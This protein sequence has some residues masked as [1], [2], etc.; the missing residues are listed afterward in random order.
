MAR[1]GSRRTLHRRQAKAHRHVLPCRCPIRGA[2]QQASSL[3][4]MKMTWWPSECHLFR[5]SV[6]TCSSNW[7]STLAGGYLVHPQF[8]VRQR[9]SRYSLPSRGHL[10]G[11]CQTP[12]RVRSSQTLTEMFSRILSSERV[13]AQ[14]E[15]TQ[16][17]VMSELP[18][19]QPRS[20]FKVE[21]VE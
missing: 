18:T 3:Q 9:S 21:K 4:E 14:P 8:P 5:C 7:E 16:N 15:L 20:Q 10:Q 1:R 12:D 19:T 6:K 11:S 13:T 2:C 17:R